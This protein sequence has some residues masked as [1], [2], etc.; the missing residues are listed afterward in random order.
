MGDGGIAN[1][2]DPPARCSGWPGRFCPQSTLD[3]F[4]QIL[5]IAV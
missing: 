5:A 4:V 3:R 2:S 1:A